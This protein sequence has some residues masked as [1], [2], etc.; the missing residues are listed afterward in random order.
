MMIRRYTLVIVFFLLCVRLSAQPVGNEWIDYSRQYFK[1]Y[2]SQN[3][4]YRISYNTLVNAGIPVGNFDPRSFQIFHNGAEQ[5]IF[6]RGEQDGIFHPG[7]YIEF[8]GKRNDGSQDT[9]LYDSPASHI[10]KNYSLFSDSSCYFLTWNSSI[11]NK[12]M[13]P[14]NDVS[15]GTYSPATYFIKSE[16]Q[17]YTTRYFTGTP[18]AGGITDPEYTSGEGWFDNGFSL[19][20]SITKNVPTPNRYLTGPPASIEFTVIG[21]SNHAQTNPDHHLYATFAGKIIDTLYEGYVVLPFQYSVPVS[22]LGQTNTTF[23]FSSV[24]DLGSAADRNTVSHIQ[25]RYPHTLNMENAS[26]FRL[27]VPDALQPKSFLNMTNFAA[28]ASDTARLYDLTNNRR[29]RVLYDGSNHK[30]LVPNSGGEKECFLTSESQIK[31]VTQLYPVGAGAYF[32]N[33]L[34]LAT[35]AQSDYIIISHKNIWQQA[36]DYKTY[37]NSTGYSCLLADIDQLYDQFAYGIL[38][39]PSGIRNFMRYAIASFPVKP[40]HLFLIGKGYRAGHDGNYPNYRKSA[41]YFE[42]TLIPSLGNPP[43]D[44]LFTARIDDSLYRPAVP[45]GRLSAKTADHVNWYLEKVIQYEIANSQP[46]EW[47]K[48]VLHFGGGSTL[49]EQSTFSAYLNNYKNIIEDTLYGGYVRTYLKT[50]TA[51]IQINQSDSLKTIINNGVSMMTF[52]GHAAGIGFDQSIDHPSEYNNYKKYPFLL[53][54]SCY[55]GDIYLDG[56]SSSEEFVLIQNKGVIGYLASIALGIP[57]ALDVFSREFYRN[58]G[59]TSY[60]KTVGQC[61]KNTIQNVQNPDLTLKETCLTFTLHGDPAIVLNSFPLPDYMIN[62][63]SVFFDP[64]VVSTEVDSFNVNVIST[65]IGMAIADSFIVYINRTFPDNTSDVQYKKIKASLYKDTLSFKFPVDLIKGV[66]LN[67]FTVTLDYYNDIAEISELNNTTDVNLL[68]KSSDIIPVY[69]YKYAVVPGLP[70]TLKAST[71][72]PFSLPTD[73]VFQLDTTDAFNSP[74]LRTY[75]VNHSGGVVQWTPQYPVTSDSIVYYWRVSVDS[76]QYQS[77]NWRESSFQYINGKSGWGQAHFY[78]FKNDRYQYVSYNKPARVF[79]FVNDIKSVFAQTGYYPYIAWNDQYYK[80]NSTNMYIWAY[81]G[82]GGNGMIVAV[83]D[84][85]NGNPWVNYNMP[86]IQYGFE[87]ST[88]S[89]ASRNALRMFLDSVPVGHHIL[90]YSHRNHN[91]QSYEEPLYQAFESFGS[92]NIRTLVNNTPYA[93]FGAKGNPVGSANEVAGASITSIIQLKDSIRTKWNEGFVE[94]ELIGPASKWGSLH[95]RQRSAEGAATDSV[96]LSVVGFGWGGTPDTLIWNLPPDSSD[97]YNLHTRIDASVYPFMKLVCFMRDDSLHTPAQLKRWQVLYE[98]APETALDPASHF[99]FHKDTVSEGEHIVFSVGTRN[100]SE[101]DMDSLL[102]SYWIIDKNRIM[103]P[104]GAFRKRPHPSGDLLADTITADTRG[105]P[106]LNSLWIE[107]NPANDQPEQY[108]FNNIGEIYFYVNRDKE[109]PL[110]DVTFDGIHIM[111][112]D[113]VSAKPEIQIMLKDENKFLL[114]NDTAN[115]R[116]YL[117]KP[118]SNVLQRIWFRRGGEEV[119]RFYPATTSR[120]SCRI[121][122][123][124]IFAEDGKYELIIQAEDMSKN[125]SGDIDYRIAF[126]VINKATITSVMNWP[127]PFSTATHFVFTITGS[128]VPTYFKI[129]IMTITGKVVREI[130]LSELGPLH[131]GRNITQ[132]AWDGKDEYGDQLANGVYLYRVI[133]RLNG[134]MIEHNPSAADKFF[135]REFGKMYLMR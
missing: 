107:V 59:Q 70:V 39:H 83:F 126:E 64:P 16:R 29:I 24:N 99:Y 120:N 115:F 109:N 78:Q 37:R 32:T 108:H 124:A 57:W 36:E 80:L 127:N 96:K 110:L 129:Q 38:K 101:Y 6:I 10:N 40:G 62:Q 12:R 11:T 61:I 90:V 26:T 122:Y 82:P 1:I 81:L 42:Q 19:G 21:A 119:M 132:Y 106:G 50:S 86:S 117:L 20:G 79:E 8:Y 46:E 113:I 43:S 14:E 74:A 13:S 75:N 34:Q 65:N 49:T 69:P 111:N 22:Q 103:H 76:G 85:V 100:V 54:N 48:N 94:S 123:P 105:L 52:F 5:Y 93:I 45:T 128:E 31:Q 51:P 72:Y 77:Y 67:K 71:G 33:Y 28:G 116:V 131:I 134:D 53:A 92:G 58:I 3:G 9:R 35:A 66:G 30:A 55:A 114:L 25:I 2:V 56:I 84:S 63:A 27:F 104:L 15:F 44:A 91:A 118:G 135:T 73:Y 97:I 95:W 102:I 88:S 68:I 130:D 4:I 60:G 18:T 23:T 41:Y 121:E 125:E 133:T 98:G 7:D 87:F 47:M 112:G 17:D 89:A